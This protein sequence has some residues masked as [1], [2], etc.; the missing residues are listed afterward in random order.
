LDPNDGRD[1]VANLPEDAPKYL[2][3]QDL[4]DHCV[5][6]SYDERVEKALGSS[7]ALFKLMPPKFE[8]VQTHTVPPPQD[9]TATAGQTFA[10]T[11][12]ECLRLK[13]ND[14]ELSTVITTFRQESGDDEAAHRLAREVVLECVL[15]LGSKSFS[16]SL[17]VFERC[18]LMSAFRMLIG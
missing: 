3:V 7:S 17:N 6:L 1:F 10:D 5:R 14:A 8:P 2:F 16:H 18:V 9:G 15:L 11:F 12:L 4:L 13:Q